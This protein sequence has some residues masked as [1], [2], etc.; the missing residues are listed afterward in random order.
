MKPLIV[1]NWKMNPMTQKEANCNFRLI[2]KAVGKINGVD[3]VVCPPF[4]FLS[5]LTPNQNIKLG[6]QDCFWEEKGSFTSGVSPLMLKNL[7]CQFVILGHSERRVYFHETDEMI[8]KKIKIALKTG[9]KV[10]LCLGEKKRQD[11]EALR[12]HL[13]K[14]LKGVKKSDFN[15]IIVAYEPVWAISGFGGRP[16]SINEAMQGALLIRE[17]LNKIF[18]KNTAKKIKILYG[19]SAN[20]N[21][22]PYIYEAAMDGLVIGSSSAKAKDFVNLLETIKP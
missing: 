18:G 15:K 4:I 21:P 1:A 22:R 14:D 17:T 16:A 10:I 13:K 6:G 7:G 3:V 9:L 11:Y 20:K 2:K 12:N 5:S 8:N 19:G